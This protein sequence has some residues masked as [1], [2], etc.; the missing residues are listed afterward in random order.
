MVYVDDLIVIGTAIF[1]INNIKKNLDQKL[2]I[3][4][5]GYLRY[6]LG[7]EITH[8]SNG[9][10]LCQH[11]YYLD[12][13]QDTCLLGTKPAATLMDPSDKLDNHA[14]FVLQDPS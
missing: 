8:F 1:D 13:F 3:K 5:L 12:L 2:S 11:K 9:I 7:F 4:D 14:T 10:T 6:F